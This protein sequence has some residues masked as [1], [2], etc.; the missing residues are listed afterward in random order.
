MLYF[1][2]TGFDETAEVAVKQVIHSHACWQH[3]L[4]VACIEHIRQSSIAGPRASACYA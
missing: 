1:K 3:A 2:A 4:L